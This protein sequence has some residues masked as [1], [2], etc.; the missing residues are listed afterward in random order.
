M[1]FKK[2]NP[3]SLRNF[4]VF[5]FNALLL[6]CQRTAHNVRPCVLTSRGFRWRQ[7]SLYGKPPFGSTPIYR[8][9]R[10]FSGDYLQSARKFFCARFMGNC[11]SLFR[12]A[13]FL[14]THRIQNNPLVSIIYIFCEGRRKPKTRAPLCGFN[15]R[16]PE[17]NCAA[18]F[19]LREIFR[20]SATCRSLASTTISRSPD[21]GPGR[22]GSPMMY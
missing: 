19:Q 9:I 10:F 8:K 22:P 14:S 6:S 4:D 20:S 11:A 2:T 3:K 7:R 13:T 17:K 12:R 1:S 16:N 18:N 5:V 15:G 21:S